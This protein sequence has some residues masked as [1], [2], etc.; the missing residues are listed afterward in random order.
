SRACRSPR[1]RPAQCPWG[2]LR[3]NLRTP[4]ALLLPSPSQCFFECSRGEMPN[5]VPAVVR[6]GDRVVHRGAGPRR[7][8]GDVREQRLARLLAD[9]ITCCLGPEPRAICDARTHDPALGNVTVGTVQPEY[10]AD[11]DEGEIPTAGRELGPGTSFVVL[12]RRE[13]D[14]G[15]NLVGLHHRGEVAAEDL[16]RWQDP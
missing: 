9:R 12:P 13:R 4:S 15:Q 5:E 3:W 14:V 1:T 6:R 7:L 2:S 8:V 10:D 11:A 16:A